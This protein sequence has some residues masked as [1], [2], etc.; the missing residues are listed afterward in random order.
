MRPSRL[1][2][3]ST[4]R[5]AL[6]YVA[7]FGVSVVGILAFVYWEAVAVVSGQTDET[8]RNEIA[9]LAEHYQER[10][11]GQ[12]I[13]VIAERSGNRFGHRGIYLLAD[14]DYRPLAGNIDAWPAVA[15]GDPGWVDFLIGTEAGPRPA[16]QLARAHTFVLPG[17]FRMLVGRDTT[18]RTE[19]RNLITEALLGALALTTLLAVAGGVVMSRNLLRRIDAINRGSQAILAGDLRRRMPIN[20]NDDEFDQLSANLNRMLERIEQLMAGM[21]NVAND[22]A[23]DLRSPISR[24]RSRLEVTLLSPQD[25]DTYRAALEETIRE[26]EEILATFN[27]ILDIALAESGALRNDF[28]DFDLTALIEDVAEFYAPVA[29]EMGSTVTVDAPASL[30]IRGNRHLLSQALANL[31]DNAVKYGGGRGPIELT[32]RREGTA[33]AVIVGD[34]GPGIPEDLRDKV[35]KRF[36]RLEASRHTPGSGLGLALVAA[37]AQL[38]DASLRLEDNKPGLRV[39]LR[40]P[41]TSASPGRKTKR[42]RLPA[43]SETG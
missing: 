2:A 31:I 34:H 26:I 22:I 6:V 35:L 18:E 25:A 14:P 38:H 36:V 37:V 24:L 43:V 1:L 28:E 21:H 8:I 3:S 23:H 15:R 42:A 40:L 4:F 29:E 11:L 12:L 27:A 19:L 41:V 7:M 5:Y 10:G 13:Q 32:V 30:A 17:G 33:A 39:V 16:R 20:G 9:S